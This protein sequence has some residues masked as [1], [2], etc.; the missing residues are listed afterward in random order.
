MEQT[1]KRSTAE[2]R[3][4]AGCLLQHMKTLQLSAG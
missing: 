3:L 4:D 1:I 2:T